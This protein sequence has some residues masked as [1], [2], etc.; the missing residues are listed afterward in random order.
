MTDF[1]FST[2]MQGNGSYYW[3]CQRLKTAMFNAGHNAVCIGDV[4]NYSGP[5]LKDFVHIHISS[6]NASYDFLASEARKKF[7]HTYILADT[8]LVKSPILQLPEWEKRFDVTFVATSIYNYFKLSRFIKIKFMPHVVPVDSFTPIEPR[9]MWFI[10]GANEQGY[11]RKGMFLAFWL[12]QAGFPVK[13]VCHN[14][15]PPGFASPNI[16]N[17]AMEEKWKNVKWYLAFSH[18]E[19]PH[20]PLVESYLH[21]VPSFYHDATEMQYIGIGVPLP[22][23][24]PQIRGQKEILAWEYDYG[25]LWESVERV[26]KYPEDLYVELS[27]AVYKYG[28]KWFGPDRL[29]DLANLDMVEYNPGDLIREAG[30]L[31]NAFQ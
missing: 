26:W 4:I 20:L 12:Q 7:G 16:S 19:S 28:K 23:G 8:V 17:E 10:I 31:R 5:S 21:G 27:K 13:A 30:E 29:K 24:Y 22:T 9:H 3:L 2:Y 25:R 11:D 1:V 6:Y 15:C 18:A 14:M